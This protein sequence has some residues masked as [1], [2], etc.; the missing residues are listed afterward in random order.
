MS[1]TRRLQFPTRVEHFY[2]G[3][4]GNTRD[5]LPF[6]AECVREAP[7]HDRSHFVEVG[8]W[9]G[10]STAFMCAEIINSRKPIAFSIV[11]MWQDATHL[12]KAERPYEP[13]T[14]TEFIANLSPV[15]LLFAS[16][17]IT[18]RPFTA[19]H[20][21]SQDAA[22]QFAQWSADMVYLDGDHSYEAVRDDIRAWW[23]VV[24]EQGGILA[25]HDY[26]NSYPGVMRAVN[27]FAEETGLT[28]E[29]MGITWKIL[30][31]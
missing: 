9:K 21:S 6:Y 14:S 24:R 10:R 29:Y 13:A 18:C 27:E 4:E 19:M 7:Y 5:I 1:Y 26:E 8:A 3:I 16:S 23:P 31:P 20:M 28:V 15:S 17:A 25:G 11:D 2:E 30:K 12:A 22:A